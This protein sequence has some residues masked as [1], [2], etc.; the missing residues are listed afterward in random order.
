[1]DGK[2]MVGY[3]KGGKGNI[4]TSGNNRSTTNLDK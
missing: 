4:N 1:M 3:N 2:E